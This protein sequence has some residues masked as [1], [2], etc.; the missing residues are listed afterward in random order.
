[1]GV[2]VRAF[3]DFLDRFA[4]RTAIFEH[5]LVLGQIAHGHFMAEGHIMEQFYVSDGFALQGHGPGGR[6]TTGG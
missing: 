3:G 2:N 6:R 1:M 4:H 5:R